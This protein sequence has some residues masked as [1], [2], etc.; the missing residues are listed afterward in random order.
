[1][2]RGTRELALAGT[3]V[4][5][6]LPELEQ[7]Q[8]EHLLFE[9]SASLQ[10]CEGTVDYLE[11]VIPFLSEQIGVAT[12]EQIRY[13]WITLADRDRLFGPLD[14]RE[15]GGIAV[16]YH[17]TSFYEPVV[18]H[19]LIHSIM[20]LNVTARFFQEGLA[21]AYEELVRGRGEHDAGNMWPDP[22]PTMTAI[23]DSDVDYPIAGSFVYYLI[24]RH[25]TGPFID[26]YTTLDGPYTL[27][28]IRAAF[29][30]VYGV[31]LDDEVERYMSGVRSCDEEYFEILA[32]RCV[33]P[34][35]PW[36]GDVWTFA[37]VL[38]CDAPGVVGGSTNRL[39]V[40]E[41]RV[42]TLEIPR[43]GTYELTA[44]VDGDLSVYLAPCFGCPWDNKHGRVDN[45]SYQWKTPAGRYHVHV[46]GDA[47]AASRFSV[48]VRP[49][50]SPP[51]SD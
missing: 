40:P 22:R 44:V 11:Q 47:H 42:T 49:I 28:R 16:G 2:N 9:H 19:E 43:D 34:V 37:D 27:A 31:E 20:G 46:E 35:S 38:A 10:V 12:P 17:A 41:F 51:A 4:A 32:A 5:A 8:G 7:I 6:C 14:G 29:R 21:V 50:E 33:A 45:G 3:L 30:R 36:R 25:G 18:E 13:S 26:F 15:S 1:M 24:A 39:E 23:T 48:T